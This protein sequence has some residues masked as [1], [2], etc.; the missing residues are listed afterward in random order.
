MS[1]KNKDIET[2]SLEEVAIDLE[3]QK[4]IEDNAALNDKILRLSAEMQN[5]KRRYDE[6]I[7]NI[8]KFDGQEIITALLPT[9][10]NFERAISM[11]DENLN[12]EFSKFLSGFKLT[13]ANMKNVLDNK[14]V[15]E[16]E[17]LNK[18]FDHN[19]MEA[20]LTDKVDG[21]EPNM[22]IEVLQ[23]GYTYNGK[24]IRYAMVK[25]SE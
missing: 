12:D 19:C 14:G 21:I 8:L 15:K 23:K 10:D 20:V 5:M 9:L 4:L 1:K 13:Y 11:D 16:I 24:V 22:V 3:K 18:E 6:Q 17:C 25:V 7:S 2:E